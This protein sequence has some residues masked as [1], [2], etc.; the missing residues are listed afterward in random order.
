M[1]TIEDQIIRKNEKLN[2]KSFLL[3]V[4]AFIGIVFICSLIGSKLLVAC[5]LIGGVDLTSDFDVFL[6]IEDPSMKPFIKAGIGLNHLF[7]FTISAIAFAYWM[8]R[9]AWQTYFQDEDIDASLITKFVILL[10]VAYPI[11]I[12]SAV[13]LEGIDLPLWV[14]SM[15]QDSIDSLM[16]ILKMD[17]IVDLLVN[18]LI[19]AILPAIGEELLFRG[20]VQNELLGK[21]E[22]HH[23]AIFIASMIFSGVHMQVQGFLPKLVIGLILGYAYYWSKSIWVPIILHFINNSIPTIML[24]LTGDMAEALESQAETPETFKLVIGVIISCFLCYLI[25]KIIHKQIDNKIT[26]HT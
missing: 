10:F 1:D 13:V 4:L 6:A 20:V 17:G 11:I 22:D 3:K 19:V 14:D 24:Y 12:A 2:E 15:D 25:I 16:N 18:L 26:Y 8:K 23:V 5:G 9:K 7:M 21:I